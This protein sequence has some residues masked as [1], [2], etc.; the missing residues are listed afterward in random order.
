MASEIPE[1][2]LNQNTET[3]DM[4]RKCPM[5]LWGLDGSTGNKKNKG[6]GK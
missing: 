1:D 5:R 6:K 2:A 4:C 3:N